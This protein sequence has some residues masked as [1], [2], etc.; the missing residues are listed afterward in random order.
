V[1]QNIHCISLRRVMFPFGGLYQTQEELDVEIS[2]RKGVWEELQIKFVAQEATRQSM[3]QEKEDG[4]GKLSAKAFE[5]LRTTIYAT[6]GH[7]HI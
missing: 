5:V 7:V 2:R 3:L 1:G 4:G 6:H